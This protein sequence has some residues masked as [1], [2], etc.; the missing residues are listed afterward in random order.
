MVAAVEHFAH[1]LYDR[2]FTI[3]TDHKALCSLPSSNTFNRRL[4]HFALKL[5]PWDIN[6]V[7]KPGRDNGN[8][9]GLS[10][11]EWQEVN[12]EPTK[13]IDRPDS[14]GQGLSSEEY[15]TP[16]PETDKDREGSVCHG[17]VSS[18]KGGVGYAPHIKEHQTVVCVFSV[19]YISYV[20]TFVSV[21]R[22][23][24]EQGW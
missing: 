15:P 12:P 21:A 2:S 20:L 16:T 4:Q 18:A 3:Y 14:P 19:I 5:Q 7:Y 8:A 9:N 13:E 24:H 17:G 23:V 10:R 6:I 1:Y 22:Q 11:Q